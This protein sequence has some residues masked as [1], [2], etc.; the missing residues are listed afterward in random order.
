[1]LDRL[2]NLLMETCLHE[3]GSL[4]EAVIAEGVDPD[5]LYLKAKDLLGT[6]SAQEKM[7]S[8]AD[9]L[10]SIRELVNKVKGY[11]RA[12]IAELRAEIEERVGIDSS[13]KPQLVFYRKLEK[14]SPED[15]ETLEVDEL[16]LDLLHGDEDE[17]SDDDSE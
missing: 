4:R 2:Q 6:L 15:R 11:S 5:R 12:R 7:D 8:A 1:M 9:Q 3:A 16:L 13:L 17:T 14:M 10:A